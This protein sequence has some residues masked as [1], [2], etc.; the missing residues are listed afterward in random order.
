MA[1]A[2]GGGPRPASADPNGI[3]RMWTTGLVLAAL[4][5]GVLAGLEPALALA[6][7]VGLAVIF[8]AAADLTLGLCM[9]IFFAF[10]EGI[11]SGAAG[12]ADLMKVFGLLLGLSWLATLAF[13]PESRN[14]FLTDHPVGAL[15][16]VGFMTWA[17]VSLAWGDSF[18][19]GTEAVMRYGLNAALLLIA[20][21]AL[22]D[23]KR[24]LWVIAAFVLGATVNAVYGIAFPPDADA[25]GISRA[26]GGAGTPHEFATMLAA[27][28][29]FG[30][31]LLAAKSNPRWMR[32]LG[33]AVIPLA[34]AGISLSLSRAGLVALG[35]AVVAAVALS[36]RWRTKMIAFALV[37]TIPI[38]GYY[39]LVAG[40]EAAE[41]I[42]TAGDGSGRTTLWQVGWRIIED[43]S[44]MGVGVGN[45]KENVIHYVVQAGAILR[46]DLVVE[47]ALIPH[48][49]YIH[50][51]AEL[52]VIGLALFLGLVAYAFF[53]AVR[54]ARIFAST[55]DL[56]LELV[57]RACAVILVAIS[58][59]NFFSSQQFNKQFWFLMALGPALL[60]L[61]RRQ[62]ASPPPP[63]LS[64]AQAWAQ[65]QDRRLPVLRTPS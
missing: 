51:T 49:V 38:A 45:Y 18:D 22:N 16:L 12:V 13:R 29:F 4:G 47:K 7:A 32:V 19:A 24:V 6:G 40:D 62:A 39:T 10:I 25:G 55:G 58:A 9:F 28:M 31:A 34:L 14:I 21:T 5:I 54:A 27:G 63:R 60:A 2:I 8:I 53:S 46:N 61:S 33:A 57:S 64:R 37:L 30:G 3:S 65:R 42:S 36:G 1:V 15:A 56:T 11:A 52:G 48:N 17:G 44:V 26:E 35:C 50:I 43:N 20:Y 59:G 41:R 23:R